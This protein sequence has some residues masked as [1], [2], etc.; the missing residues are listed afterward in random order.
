[1]TFQKLKKGCF[2][3]TLFSI[4]TTHPCCITKPFVVYYENWGNFYKFLLTEKCLKS[5]KQGITA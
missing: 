4:A 1:M 2:Y 3:G 5:L